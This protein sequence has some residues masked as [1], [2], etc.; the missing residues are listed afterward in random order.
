MLEIF[1]LGL[2]AG[3]L[4]GVVLLYRKVAVPLKE[5]KKKIEEKKRSLSVL[6]GKITE[7]F[8]PFMKNYPYNP[9]KFRFIG[10]PI[11]GVQF[12]E[13]RIIFVEFKTANSKL[14]NEEK[15]IKKLVEDKKV[16]WMDFEIKWE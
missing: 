7:Q 6:Y 5:E 10:S 12:E 15:K 9:K 2:L 4:A 13:D 11:D 8:A 16:E 3:F 1:L 14:S